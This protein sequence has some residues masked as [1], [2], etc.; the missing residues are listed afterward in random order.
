ML[1]LFVIPVFAQDTFEASVGDAGAVCSDSP[2]GTVCYGA[3]DISA[4]FTNDVS[5]DSVGD[6]AAIDSLSEVTVE[7]GVAV[8]KIPG[9]QVADIGRFLTMAAIGNVQLNNVFDP[10]TISAI[11]T[12]ANLSSGNINILARPNTT[13]G[14]AGEIEPREKFPVSGITSDS[15]WFR[16]EFNNDIAWVENPTGSQAVGI[17]CDLT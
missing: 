8:A 16:I 14:I 4:T 12:G 2:S 9:G 6:F 3:G 13:G 10:A 5:L 1:A 17:D 7:D 11:C 15:R